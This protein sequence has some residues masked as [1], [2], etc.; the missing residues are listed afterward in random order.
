MNI[1][2]SYTSILQL[3]HEVNTMLKV[4]AEDEGK[5]EHFGDYQRI[6]EQI[7]LEDLTEV[8]KFTYYFIFV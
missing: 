1:R 2:D 8:F 3:K 5:A 7:P 6:V 4:E